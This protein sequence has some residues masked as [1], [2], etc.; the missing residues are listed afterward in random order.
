M[1]LKICGEIEKSQTTAKNTN[2]KKPVH[3]N[4]GHP[5]S[6]IGYI[7]IKKED[8]C[9]IPMRVN[10]TFLT[11]QVPGKCEALINHMPHEP[12]TS[13]LWFEWTCENAHGCGRDKPRRIN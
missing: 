1:G 10:A 6:Q 4:F 2:L 7:F 13:R 11:G 3:T 9:D 5:L 8:P 12:S